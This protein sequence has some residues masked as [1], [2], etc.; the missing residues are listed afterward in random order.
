MDI[1]GAAL[2]L[3]VM[4]SSTGDRSDAA[5]AVVFPCSSLVDAALLRPLPFRDAYQLVMIHKDLGGRQKGATSW[6]TTACGRRWLVR[7]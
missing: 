2:I 7:S 3:Q 5:D 6:L 4:Q 1:H